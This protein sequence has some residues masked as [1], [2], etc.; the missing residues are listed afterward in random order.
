MSGRKWG[1]AAKSGEMWQKL[2]K[3]GNKWQ[4]AAKGD[5]NVKDGRQSPKGSRVGKPL[6]LTPP[7]LIRSHLPGLESNPRVA[8]H[9]VDA[10]AQRQKR[11]EIAKRVRKVRVA[12]QGQ[13]VFCDQVPVSRTCGIP[14]LRRGA[15]KS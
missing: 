1:N 6:L 4:K 14:V 8:V 5:I 15:A 7:H 11:A 9:A 2:A 10:V 12:Q 13:A 3:S